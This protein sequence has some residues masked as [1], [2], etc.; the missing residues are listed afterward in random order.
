MLLVLVAY[1]RV[2]SVLRALVCCRINQ[3]LVLLH[4]MGVVTLLDTYLDI[5]DSLSGMS[6]SCWTNAWCKM[7]F[8][9]LL[10]CGWQSYAVLQRSDMSVVRLYRVKHNTIVTTKRYIPHKWHHNY[11][12]TAPSECSAFFIEKGLDKC[13]CPSFGIL[14]CWNG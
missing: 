11:Y 14:S 9:C 12:A 1:S 10:T 13:A 2:T 7:Y 8:L 3:C 5:L 6:T 4:I